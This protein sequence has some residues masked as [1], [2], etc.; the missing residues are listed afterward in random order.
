MVRFHHHQSVN[1]FASFD[2]S[3]GGGCMKKKRRKVP[4]RASEVA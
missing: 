2:A 4:L 1:N 3:T